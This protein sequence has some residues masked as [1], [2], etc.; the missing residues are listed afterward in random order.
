MRRQPLYIGHGADACFGWLHV[1]EAAPPRDCAAVLCGPI[2]HEYTRAHRTLRHLADR[3]AARGIPALRF[4]Y[5]GIGD[6]PGT[7]LDPHRVE[8]WL[9]D[10]RAAVTQTRELTGRPRI[11]L[12]GVRFG[13]TLAAMA[14]WDTTAD[15]LVL[16]NPVLKGKAYIRE[17]QAIAMTAERTASEIEGALESAGFVMSAETIEKIRGIDLLE[18]DV[19]AGHVLVV[20]RDDT[21]QDLSLNEKLG[22][23]GIENAYYRAPG[24]AGMMAEHQFTVVPDEALDHIAEW[25]E[26]HSESHGDGHSPVDGNPMAL[27]EH[28]PPSIT[29][30]IETTAV[31]E[32][33]L[34]FGSDRHLFGVLTSGARGKDRPAILMFNAGS[35]HHVGPNRIYVGLARHLAAA[36]FDSLRFDLESLGDSVLRAPGRENYPYPHT[37]TSDAGAALDLLK[38]RGYNRIIALGLCSGAHTTFHAGLQFTDHPIEE[39]I[40]INP[41]SFYW[42]EGNSLDTSRRFED[43][44]A[45]K[46]S[47]RDPRRWLKLLRGDVNTKRLCE[48]VVSLVRNKLRFREDPRLS[49]DLRKLIDEFNRPITFFIAEGDP[50]RDILMAGAPRTAR[51][52]LK[53]GRMRF[54]MIPGADHTFSQFKPRRDLMGRLNAHLSRRAQTGVSSS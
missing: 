48:A 4:D 17:L 3:L 39:L 52:A 41:M 26:C 8:R 37:A 50:G 35:A 42:K 15:L 54:E 32:S 46:R 29:F 21:A 9:G 38:S 44:A 25:V 14:T 22:E 49:S 40:L 2:G 5:H 23:R 19:H 6:S 18:R 34:Q 36:G 33:A 24:W 28:E 13:A 45:Y 31:T 27:A 11:C 30:P 20:A 47:M 51:R 10:I 16:W 1:D 43:V 12:V 7:D 53:R